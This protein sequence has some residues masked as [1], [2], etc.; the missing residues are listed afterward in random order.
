MENI[1]SYVKWRGD[2]SFAERGFNEVDNAVF[3][4]VSYVN[5]A[6]IVPAPGHF[7]SISIQETYDLLT[8]NSSSPEQNSFGEAGIQLL[9]EMCRAKR[10]QTLRLSNYINVFDEAKVIQFS[11]LHFELDD[12][13][14][15]IAFCG[16]DDSIVGWHENFMMSFQ[17]VPAQRKA[18]AYLEETVDPAKNYLLGGHSKG[19]NLAVYGGMNCSSRVR[20]AIS[21]IYDNDGPGFS[22]EL[23][24]RSCYRYIKDRIIRI[25]PEFSVVGML[26]HQQAPER[27]VASDLKGV[28]QHNLFSWQVEGEKFVKKSELDLEAQE[29]NTAIERSLKN[30]SM[31]ERKA[32]VNGLFKALQTNGAKKITD[33]AEDGLSSFQTIFRSFDSGEGRFRIVLKNLLRSLTNFPS[34][35]GAVFFRNKELL[36]STFF[37]FIGLLFILL[38]SLAVQMLGSA[39]WA[40]LLLLS[41]YKMIRYVQQI[42]AGKRKITMR[43]K[44]FFFIGIFTLWLLLKQSALIL[45]TNFLLGGVFLTYALNRFDKLS[46]KEKWWKRKKYQTAEPFIYLILGIIALATSDQVLAIYIIFAGV[47]IFLSS[48]A[49]IVKAL[50]RAKETK[51]QQ[52]TN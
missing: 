25:I 20:Y 22:D 31:M 8:K 18:V 4:A 52:G 43:V 29:Y 51:M 42:I 6:G 27:V 45:S 11:A 50:N 13:N 48:A 17:A 26:F 36:I 34:F 28:S 30:A 44:V 10:F 23:L 12:Q 24:S 37:G 1:I 41:V 47:S 49:G 5:F 7:A 40:V 19:G 2:I 33:I 38:P 16:T 14:T 35:Q 3:S 46:G 21:S 39:L 32:F 9:G 15:Y